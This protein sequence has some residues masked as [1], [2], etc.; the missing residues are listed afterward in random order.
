MLTYCLYAFIYLVIGMLVT[1]FLAHWDRDYNHILVMFFWPCA[2]MCALSIVM[3]NAGG[4]L[5]RWIE[6]R[7]CR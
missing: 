2:V 3:F 5:Y 1:G 4:S 6:R 7:K